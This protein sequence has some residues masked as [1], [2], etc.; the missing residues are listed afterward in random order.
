MHYK[1]SMSYLTRNWP[2]HCNDAD[3][4]V[5]SKHKKNGSLP[6]FQMKRWSTY[7]L[8]C[9]DHNSIDHHDDDDD[10]DV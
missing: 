5:K 1:H 7:V 9:A 6:V 8:S 3:Q 4:S 10:D 2:Y